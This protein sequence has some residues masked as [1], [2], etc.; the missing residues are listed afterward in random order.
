L[1]SNGYDWLQVK[2]KDVLNGVPQGLQPVLN[3]IPFITFGPIPRPNVRGTVDPITRIVTLSPFWDDMRT[4]QSAR[5]PCGQPG[6]GKALD[7]VVYHEAR[8]AYQLSQRN[9]PGNDLDGDYL[10]DLIQ[11]PPT[12]VLIDST[13]SRTVCDQAGGGPFSRSYL[14]PFLPDAFNL[15]SPALEMDAWRFAW[16]HV[17]IFP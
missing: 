13:A 3:A 5:S 8:H 1:D 12:D 16:L 11:L 4:S 7:L 10:L 2:V 14:G 15:V 6:R 17:F 9:L